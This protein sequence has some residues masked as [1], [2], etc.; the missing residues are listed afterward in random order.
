MNEKIGN[1]IKNQTI[2]TCYLIFGEESYLCKQNRKKLLEALVNKGDTMNYAAFEGKGIDVHKVID[3]AETMPFFAECR[4]ILLSN[5][6]LLKGSAPEEL[7]HYIKDIPP[8]TCLIFEEEEVDKRSKLY[9]AIDKC[10]AAVEYPREREETIKK[11]ILLKL[12]KENKK[13]TGTVLDE[14]MRRTGNDMERIDKEL[15]KLFCYT[16]ERDVITI[17][18]VD[19]VCCG[20]LNNNIFDM[21][22]AIAKREE[23]KAFTLYYELL[24]Q[25]EAPLHILFLVTRQFRNL[26]QVK[27]LREKGYDASAIASKT[28]LPSF[29]VKM[30]IQQATHF[31]MEEL[32]RAIYD[33]VEAESN[34]KMGKMDERTALELFLVEH[35]KKSPA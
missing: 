19:A 7:I 1:D 17:E 28:K 20:Q 11:W 30:N 22:N 29:G 3:L 23:K 33:G 14:F 8:A 24:R 2:Q 32:K 35:T 31:T 34:I 16:L 12:K 10:G 13:I 5:T 26:L 4:V 18:D 27:E 6:G 9:K 25:K 21:V 15:E